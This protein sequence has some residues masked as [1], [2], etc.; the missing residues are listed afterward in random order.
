MT[1]TRARLRPLTALLLAFAALAARGAPARAQQGDIPDASQLIQ[2]ATAG[3]EVP[4]GGETKARVTITIA[5][6]WHVNANPPARDYLIATEA[7]VEAAS[8]LTPGAV[9][10][11]PAKK[12]KLGFEDG[13]LAVYDGEAV[14][15]IPVAAAATAPAGERTLT[16]AIRFQACNDQVCL[17]PAVVAFTIPVRVTAA[18]ATPVSPANGTPI[19]SPGAPPSG[20]AAGAPVGS[21]TAAGAVSG[22][23]TA[24]PS[25]TSA[26]TAKGLEGAMGR[27]GLVWF[28]SLFVG[29]LL[30]NLTPC[31]FPMLGVTVSIFGARRREPLPRVMTAA[32]LYVLGIVVMYSTL[33]VVAALTGGLFGSALQSVWVN[34][35]LGALLI[36]LS[37]SMFGFYEMQPPAWLL[38]RLGGADT[39]SGVGLFLSGLA[40]GIIAAP[41]VGPFV[42][43]VLAVIAR[44]ADAVFGFETMFALALGLG[45]PYLFLASFSNLL[46]RLPRSG[47]WMVWVKKGFGVILAAIGVFYPL[48]AFAP[49]YAVWVLPAALVLGGLFLGFADKSADAQRGFRPL[50]M[51]MGALAV[52]GGFVVIATTPKQ[53]VAFQPYESVAL[54]SGLSQGRTAMIDF[55]ASWCAPCHE[56]DRYTMTD[57]HVRAYARTFLVYRA[58]LTRYDSP[59]SEALRRRY[60][61]TGVPTVVFLGPDGKE[62]IE[63]RVEGFIPPA[64]FLERMKYAAEKTRVM[65]PKQG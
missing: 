33:G 9:H 63:A 15:E 10:Y 28:L 46:Q 50:R 54:Q 58:D 27:G 22:L 42:V 35:G 30:L 49:D 48:V 39:T 17:A 4:A 21:G 65:A 7:K 47:S 14:L 36:A 51:V 34:I 31:V 55:S 32:A 13:E 8:A 53:S 60:G 19:A 12:V 20:A 59:E 64:A 5:K 56:L 45:F 26:A 38:T 37:L 40:V 62:V 44:R 41:C 6:G 2:V 24:P 3:I 43:A 29:G 1:M 25:G 16:G 18:A 11:P 61:I 52:V 23:V 57:D